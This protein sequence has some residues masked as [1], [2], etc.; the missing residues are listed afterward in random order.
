MTI[1]CTQLIV[2]LEGAVKGG[3]AERRV[4]IL[5]QVTCLFLA[6]LDQLK[7]HHIDVYDGVFVRL[8]E[9]VDA[10]T[11]ARLSAVL[12]DLNSTPTQ[13]V[14]RLA[15]HEDAA[16]A[17]PVLLKSRSIVEQDLV[18]IAGTRAQQ[19]L[20]AVAGRKTLSEI[21]TEILL[22][23]GDTHVC[24]MLAKNDGARFSRRG[25]S[26]LID[27][28][29]RDDEI[30][31]SLVHRSDVTAET[32]CE[33]ISKTTSRIHDRLLG[34]A[35]PGIRGTIAIAI[36]SMAAEAV[37]KRPAP[38]D[39]SEARSAVLA[40]NNAGKLNDSSINRFAVRGENV[41]LIAALSLL[42]D[43][44]IKTVEQLI[45]ESDCHGLVIA[46]R[47]SRLNWQTTLAVIRNC[48]RARQIP[49]H[50]IEQYK[51]LFES[52]FLSTAQ[53]TIRHGP[54]RDVTSR[55]GSSGDAFATLRAH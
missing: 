2:E 16:I 12:A 18:E 38:I 1:A 45:R 30:A 7:E 39:Y 20:L 34:V 22:I 11:L 27:A 46:C 55:I 35:P 33:L 41:N 23:R 36:D 4:Q 49:E 31:D 14:R 25:L 17:G 42:A 10:R 53:R 29:G 54:V 24:R 21:L 8:I 28:A 48:R 6:S 47:A 5:R 3:S 40:L 15:F 13:A 52:L 26:K 51:E 44:T 50:D 19:H 37:R 43:V 9:C 32:I